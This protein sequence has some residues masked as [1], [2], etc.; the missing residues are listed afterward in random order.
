MTVV[1]PPPKI[2]TSSNLEEFCSGAKNSTFIPPASSTILG[3]AFSLEIFISSE[4]FDSL[5][6][7]TLKDSVTTWISKGAHD[8]PSHNFLISGGHDPTNTKVSIDC[9]F[10]VIA[11]PQCIFSLS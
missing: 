10:T 3:L 5:R 11:G 4:P 1:T 9:R 8:H 2:L 6:P 7:T